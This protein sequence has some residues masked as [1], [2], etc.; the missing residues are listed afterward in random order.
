MLD[1][2]A[3]RT[4][5]TVLWRTG[6]VALATHIVPLIT[7]A[8]DRYGRP[9]PRVLV[10]LPVIATGS[11]LAEQEVARQ[12]VDDAEAFAWTLPTYRKAFER[13]V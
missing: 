13:E 2:A 11:S 1:L 9:A 7:E 4:V 10:G 5:G 3:E 12:F 6:P 8:A